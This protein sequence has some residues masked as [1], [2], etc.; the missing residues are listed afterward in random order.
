MDAIFYTSELEWAQSNIG[1]FPRWFAGRH[2]ADPCRAGFYTSACYRAVDGGLIL[3]DM[4]QTATWNVF[5]RQSYKVRDKDP[6][7]KQML[8]PRTASVN[9]VYTYH[10]VVGAG[11][12]LRKTDA[13]WI[14]LICFVQV[15]CTIEARY[16]ALDL[17]WSG[18]VNNTDASRCAFS[19]DRTLDDADQDSIVQWLEI[20]EV[21]RLMT[22]GATS[23]RLV[24]RPKDRPS[25]SSY[26]PRWPVLTGWPNQPPPVLRLTA[27]LVEWLGGP[28]AEGDAF[29]G[30]RLYPWPDDV[31]LLRQTQPDAI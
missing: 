10:P 5:T 17:K 1:P 28:L 19:C 3:V 22:L 14:G 18:H 9:T 21:A 20:T 26:R 30:Y 16:V 12:S 2:S 6:Y 29:V 31:A 24:R 4:Y 7:A 23:V 8:A 25:T 13:D 27:P 11:D 15:S